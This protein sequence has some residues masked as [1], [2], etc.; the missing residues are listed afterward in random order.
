M[1]SVRFSYILPQSK[2]SN[3]IVPGLTKAGA[4]Q[5]GSTF[6]EKS[7]LL[8]FAQKALLFFFVFFFVV[9]VVV[10]AKGIERPV[11]I[12]RQEINESKTWSRGWIWFLHVIKQG[13][14][15]KK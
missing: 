12:S 1:P 5:H 10:L 9:V 15:P 11:L 13:R 6:L 4:R 2:Y 14:D 8:L 3:T 7:N